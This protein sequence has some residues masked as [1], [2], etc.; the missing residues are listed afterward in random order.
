MKGILEQIKEYEKTDD[1]PTSKPKY[2]INNAKKIEKKSQDSNIEAQGNKENMKADKSKVE[3]TKPD[4]NTDEKQIENSE[5]NKNEM[6]DEDKNEE[7]K[8]NQKE[9]FLFVSN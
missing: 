9:T 1:V 2:D 4:K 8:N 7:K 5:M 6:K 3:N